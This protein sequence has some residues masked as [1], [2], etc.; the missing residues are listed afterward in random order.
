[1][2]LQ[3]EPRYV[4]WLQLR[5]EAMDDH[6]KI[7]AMRIQQLKRL[8]AVSQKAAKDEEAQLKQQA[9][10]SCASINEAH[11]QE[12]NGI[13]W[14]PDELAAKKSVLNARLVKVTKQTER[15]LAESRAVSSWRDELI[16]VML[17]TV[18]AYNAHQ[19]GSLNVLTV[20][21]E[22]ERARGRGVVS[23]FEWFSEKQSS[24]GRHRQ[25]APCKRSRESIHEKQRRSEQLHG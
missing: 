3:A 15:N 2:Q 21:K 11:L 16:G 18:D 17:T 4:A 20:E 12:L 23:T 14:D 9:E 25:V 19:L 10:Q 5:E 24:V 6:S 1:V 13:V 8:S 7:C 22:E